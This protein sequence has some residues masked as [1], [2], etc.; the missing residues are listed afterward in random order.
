MDQAAM[1]A[2]E[3]HASVAEFMEVISRALSGIEE[4]GSL[5]ARSNVL[6]ND[7]GLEIA[8]S[9]AVAP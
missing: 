4:P 5:L 6:A 2:D 9:H 8:R 3:V 7:L 1:Y